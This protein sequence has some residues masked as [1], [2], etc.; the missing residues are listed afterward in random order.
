VET[1]TKIHG[2]THSSIAALA[3]REA[4]PIKEDTGKARTPMSWRQRIYFV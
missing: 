3:L 1:L 4:L 2:H